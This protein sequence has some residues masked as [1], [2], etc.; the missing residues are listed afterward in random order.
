MYVK[1]AENVAD[2]R[3]RTLNKTDTSL[4][5]TIWDAVKKAFRGCKGHTMDL[6][7]LDSNCMTDLQGELLKQ[8]FPFRTPGSVGIN[9][10][11]QEITADK[12]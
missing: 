3:S 10:L 1:S 4:K 9:G 12:N 8:Y 7:S 2:A 5:R 11:S 6:M